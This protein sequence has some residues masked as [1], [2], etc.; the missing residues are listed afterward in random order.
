MQVGMQS[1]NDTN[2]TTKEGRRPSP[3]GFNG[4]A[5]VPSEASTA[6]C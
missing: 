3:S 5:V 1:A 4:P 2:Q 6:A